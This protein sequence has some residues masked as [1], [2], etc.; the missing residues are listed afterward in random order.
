MACSFTGFASCPFSP[1]GL[2]EI[3]NLIYATCEMLETNQKILLS[4]GSR[5]TFLTLF[6]CLFLCYINNEVKKN[7]VSLCC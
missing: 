2:Y 3:E 1:L 5:R 4:R 6:K 7:A